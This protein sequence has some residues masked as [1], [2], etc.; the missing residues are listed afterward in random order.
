M[1]QTNQI[2]RG[3]IVDF[4]EIHYQL[5]KYNQKEESKTWLKL[6]VIQS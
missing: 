1:Y 3:N 6:G 2:K 5:V 4:L